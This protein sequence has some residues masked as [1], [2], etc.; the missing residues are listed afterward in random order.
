MK[1]SLLPLLLLGSISQAADEPLGFRTH[2]ITIVPKAPEW[3]PAA[4]NEFEEP[5]PPCSI[6]LQSTVINDSSLDSP[7]FPPV[8]DG[9][10]CN[11]SFKGSL[12][13]GKGFVATKPTVLNHSNR[14]GLTFISSK[15]PTSSKLQLKGELTY[16]IRK[17]EG[18][19]LSKAVTIKGRG[20]YKTDG[21]TIHYLPD[22]GGGTHKHSFMIMPPD[23]T[24]TS[25]SAIDGVIFKDTNG[26][27]WSTENGTLKKDGVWYSEDAVC[28]YTEETAASDKG[29]LQIILKGK[30][31]TVSTKLNQTINLEPQPIASTASNEPKQV[32]YR[33][34]CTEFYPISKAQI[35]DEEE[36]RGLIMLFWQQCTSPILQQRRKMVEEFVEETG[37]GFVTLQP[38]FKGTVTDETGFQ[39]PLSLDYVWDA[40]FIFQVINRESIPKGLKLRVE[41]T[42]S[43]MVCNPQNYRYTAAVQLHDKI[44]QVVEDY[45]LLWDKESQTITVRVEEGK[46]ADLKRICGLETAFHSCR[47]EQ[48]NDVVIFHYTPADDRL[49][50]Q[51]HPLEVKLRIL[52][53]GQLYSSN[54]NQLIDLSTNK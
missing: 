4:T 53:D 54:I 29:S 1:I 44:T 35:D 14:I 15:T 42:I 19:E 40:G 11:I 16:T 28:F 18:T 12:S 8:S 41:G 26:K 33:H 2:G 5:I 34:V 46:N 32:K 50:T 51:E 37:G 36:E 49:H 3:V 17:G 24:K 9:F 39:I 23:R 22:A 30:A 13:D 25:A 10:L 7:D 27:V 6:E 43:Y 31:H 21:Y 38:Q 48:E 45:S 20:E 47:L 52:K